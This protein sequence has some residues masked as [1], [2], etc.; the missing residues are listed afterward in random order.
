M[1]PNAAMPSAESSPPARDA[2]EEVGVADTDAGQ[3]VGRYQPLPPRPLFRREWRRFPEALPRDSRALAS[4]GVQIMPLDIRR[5]RRSTRELVV[6]V[7][8]DDEEI[9]ITLTYRPDAML[10]PGMAHAINQSRKR[11]N[12]DL[13]R[14]EAITDALAR[15]LDS[16]DVTEDGMPYPPT[17]ENLGIFDVR[18][19]LGLFNAIIED[20]NRGSVPALAAAPSTDDAAVLRNGHDADRV[21]PPI[22]AE[23]PTGREDSSPDQ[24]ARDRLAADQ[25]E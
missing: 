9:T 1:P 21:L 18:L 6:P 15:L 5:M 13:Q 17:L 22:D 25:P 3:A 10:T 7:T 2:G 24:A 4:Y 19:L 14:S 11:G 12:D 20:V 8:V 16:W 23:P